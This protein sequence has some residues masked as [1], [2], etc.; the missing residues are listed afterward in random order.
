MPHPL[1]HV[2]AA[3][4]GQYR[5]ER[6]LGHGGMATVYLAED[7]KHGRPVAIKVLD[8]DLSGVLGADRFL[9]EIRIA[10]QLQHP[11][12]LPL[13]D[14]GAADGLL[15]YVM[16]FVKDESLRMHLILTRQLPVDE[17]LRLAAEVAAA[18]DYSHRQGMVHRDIKPENVLLAD[19][20][21]VVADF[22][23]A[24]AIHESGGERLT[25]TGVT[26]GSP[27]YMS[28][29][30]SAG[31][32][33]VDGRSDLYAL[34]CVLYEMLVGQPPFSGPTETLPHQHLN[35]APRRVR[36]LRPTVPPAV[37]ATVARS[38][39]K[40]PADRFATGA[41]F[42]TALAAATTTPT[43][44]SPVAPAEPAATPDSVPTTP[45]GAGIPAPRPHRRR[46][47]TI[48]LAVA[49]A[50]VGVVGAILWRSGAIRAPSAR[51]TGGRQ[52][53]W[54]A[55]F[56]GPGDDPSLGPTARDLVAATLDQ[57][58]VLAS[59]PGDQVRSALRN[60][61]RPDTMRAN[62]DLAR[63]LAFRSGIPVVVSGR[64]G[65]LGSSYSIV[66]RALRAEDGRV[67]YSANASAT[68]ERE[69]A[70]ALNKAARELRRGLGE[71]P[72]TLSQPVWTDA[73]TPSF[74]AFKL[75]SRGR[76]LIGADNA[77]GAV[78]A[79][80]EALAIDPDFA[81]AWI[82]LGTAIG[83]L[84]M[85]DSAL[86]LQREALR[87]PDRLSAV[88][89]L[90]LEAKTAMYRGD[91][92]AT[93]DA[94]DA[95]LELNPSPVDRSAALNN[96]ALALARLGDNEQALARF[97]EAVTVF[98]IE[99]PQI[100][101]SNVV[102][103]L[104]ALRRFDEARAMMPK[105][106]GSSLLL[107]ALALAC[108]EKR[109]DRADSVARALETSQ[110]A[111][112][113]NARIAALARA[114][115]R[116][117]R[118]E[119]EDG[120]KDLD[121]VRLKRIEAHDTFGA[122]GLWMQEAW[123]V[124]VAGRGSMPAPEGVGGSVFAPVTSAMRAALAGDSTAA[125]AAVAAWPESTLQESRDPFVQHVEGLLAWRSGRWQQ[126]IDRL[127]P[128]GIGGVYAP[129]RIEEVIRPPARWIVADA[130]E[131]LGRRDSAIVWFQRLLDPPRYNPALL[132]TSGMWEP[133][134]R[135]RLVTLYA[136]SGEVD[137]AKREWERLS[138]TTVRPDPTML[139][140]LEETRGRLQ[141]AS[142]LAGEKR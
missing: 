135:A 47:R 70:P 132:N 53:I 60:S 25:Q 22:G 99:A 3:L 106:R 101:L 86:V 133:F 54:L 4:A 34:G 29:E 91:T 5:V 113:L 82:G 80:R 2:R 76:Q 108:I 55:D 78:A 42:A 44:P 93:I 8:P 14:S 141:A 104:I 122:G 85:P 129:P 49:L 28:P 119:V 142:A 27:T 33:D 117:A 111:R 96:Q 24:R 18:L 112:S 121:A 105:L 50:T 19:G 1:E 110:D 130:Y 79:F 58:Q 40:S 131:H 97:R 31:G 48:A 38:L 59:V 11:N 71:N 92:R 62:P 36:E 69:L 73:A 75:F 37:D 51:A 52:W 13:L 127:A 32:P 120:L 114:T 83:N 65:R 103:Q 9:R 72:Q 140:M 139:A 100:T 102:D 128:S 77:F 89:K 16:P 81:A 125:R 124:E 21:A 7:V 17:A 136:E 45:S 15:Y 43:P 109:W 137:A 12:I 88:R 67:I 26:L 64:I 115:I 39:A 20:H 35:V 57:S 84:G 74:E 30:Q 126:A 56:E 118:G 66:L 98:P 41:E 10:A 61:G 68:G 23:I 63:E 90:E 107:Q 116:V 46:A 95:L 6:E 138:A 134:A 87:H 94:Y 123:L